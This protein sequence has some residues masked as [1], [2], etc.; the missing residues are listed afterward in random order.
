MNG[1][2]DTPT[3]SQIRFLESAFPHRAFAWT[4]RSAGE[5]GSNREFLRV[6]TRETGESWVLIMWNSRDPEWPRLLGISSDLRN[7][8]DLLP[9]I[10]HV[11][12]RAGMV[13]MQDLGSRDLRHECD[14]ISNSID[15]RDS[16]VGRVIDALIQWQAIDVSASPCIASNL[17]DL[18]S[19]LGETSLFGRYFV[20]EY[21]ALPRALDADWEVERAK[22]ATEVNTLK[23]SIIHRDMHSENIMTTN[24][25]VRF[26]D[27]SG[28]S[29]GPAE[30]DLAALLF[31]P[32]LN[33]EPT[34]INKLHARYRTRFT[35]GNPDVDHRA[36]LACSA[37]RLMNVLGA[38]SRFVMYRR[39]YRYVPLIPLSLSNFISVLEQ[40]EDY[41]R[42]SA[43]AKD[44]VR[45]MPKEGDRQPTRRLRKRLRWR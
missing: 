18:R 3:K 28:A 11:N 36:L 24:D 15:D 27:F 21:C 16:A 12:A 38:H 43:L 29:L 25:R 7:H 5:G 6:T 22:L 34:S 39:E 41:P 26:V 8:T 2:S 9:E 35:R 45:A 37:L 19:L 33:L 4:V 10:L 42:I 30:Y 32:L 23:P 17:M 31:D 14:S 40:L 44:C 13:L 20:S 1:H